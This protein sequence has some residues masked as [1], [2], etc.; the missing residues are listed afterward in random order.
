MLLHVKRT[1]CPPAECY[2]PQANADF[3]FGTPLPSLSWLV[4][5]GR[6]CALNFPI[7]MNAGLAKALG[8]MLKLDFERAVLNRVPVIPA[9]RGREVITSQDLSLRRST[10]PGSSGIRSRSRNTPQTFA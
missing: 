9:K 8:V 7:A 1:F 4:E 3:K 6:V 5:N 10:A 2:D